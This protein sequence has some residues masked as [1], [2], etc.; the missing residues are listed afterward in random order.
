MKRNVVESIEVTQQIFLE[1]KRRFLSLPDDYFKNIGLSKGEAFSLIFEQACTTYRGL[2]IEERY[3]GYEQENEHIEK[4]E[5][6]KKKNGKEHKA[7]EKQINYIMS[8]YDKNR[9][10]QNIIHEYIQEVGK[11]KIYD[12]NTKEASELIDRL[13]HAKKR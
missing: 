7:T 9:D 5:G 1:V 6:E 3:R 11:Q 8:F 13:I 12:L 2:L 10:Y 4:E